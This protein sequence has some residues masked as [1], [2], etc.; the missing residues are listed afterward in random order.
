MTAPSP[1]RKADVTRALA[2]AAAAGLKV[3]AV[4][5]FPEGSFKIVTADGS[6]KAKPDNE[7]DEVLGDGA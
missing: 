1:F 5:F 3:A 7:W 4:K 6:E 2:A